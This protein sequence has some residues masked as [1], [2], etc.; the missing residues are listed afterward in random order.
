MTQN[1]TQR[2]CAKK[3]IQRKSSRE[4]VRKP[5]KNLAEN[6]QKS[7]NYKLIVNQ[8][9]HPMRVTYHGNQHIRDLLT[10]F[11]AH[12]KDLLQLEQQLND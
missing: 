10:I 2:I 12:L 3:I 4:S 9:L 7:K 8:Y 1:M 11:R 5:S 6:L